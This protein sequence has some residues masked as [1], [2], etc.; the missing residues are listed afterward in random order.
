MFVNCLLN[1]FV[2]AMLCCNFLFSYCVCAVVFYMCICMLFLCFLLSQGR[3][4]LPTDL[5]LI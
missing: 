4:A 5:R 1:C 2:C 3:T